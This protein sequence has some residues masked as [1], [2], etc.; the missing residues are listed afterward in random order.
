MRSQMHNY[1]RII[2]CADSNARVRTDMPK[3]INGRA[4]S[5]HAQRPRVALPDSLPKGEG[6]GEGAV[7][8]RRNNFLTKSDE[9]DE[10]PKRNQSET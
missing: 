6:A 4:F 2:I 8:R 9:F 10:Q 7:Q 1:I 5:H 3:E